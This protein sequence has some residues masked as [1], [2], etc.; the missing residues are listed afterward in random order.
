MPFH[1]NPHKKS[2]F[3]PKN[4]IFIFGRFGGIFGRAGGK[5]K[6]NI[7]KNSCVHRDSPYKM[8]I[9]RADFAS[10]QRVGQFWAISLPK[11]PPKKV[12]K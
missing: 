4:D 10:D 5:N 6:I 3:A 7:N 2:P 1:P 12:Q 8:E 9:W 11:I